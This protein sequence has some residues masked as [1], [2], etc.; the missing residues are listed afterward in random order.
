MGHPLK[1]DRGEHILNCLQAMSPILQ[2]ELVDLW[3]AV[4]PKLLKY[5]DG[6]E[7]MEHA[8]CNLY[9][10]LHDK[11]YDHFCLFFYYSRTLYG[12]IVGPETLGRSYTEGNMNNSFLH[13]LSFSSPQFLSR[14]VDEL[15]NEDWLLEL[16]NVLGDKDYITQTYANYPDDKVS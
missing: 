4:I 16:G 12:W 7:Y 8:T 11:G 3:D 9:L 13:S 1:G 15:S 6:K 14:S 2:E 5:L 10:Y